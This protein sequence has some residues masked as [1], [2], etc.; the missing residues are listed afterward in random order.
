MN[1][2]VVSIS[3]LVMRTYNDGVGSTVVELGGEVGLLHIRLKLD[4]FSD[5]VGSVCM[6]SRSKHSWE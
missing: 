5:P 1:D 3:R 6:Y 4:S 2:H